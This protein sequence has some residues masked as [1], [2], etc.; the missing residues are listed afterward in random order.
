MY[1]GIIQLSKA[2]DFDGSL[3]GLLTYKK[4]LAMSGVASCGALI[5]SAIQV[6][7]IYG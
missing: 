1:E 7:S 4:V 2:Q 5:S 3:V 6:L